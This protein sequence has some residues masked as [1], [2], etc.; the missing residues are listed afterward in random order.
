VTD[1]ASK[2]IAELSQT[3]NEHLY[4]YHVQDSPTISDAQYDALF[5]ELELL[6]AKHPELIKP[7]SPTHRVLFRQCVYV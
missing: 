5:K 6:E 3:L 2:K 7:D 4:R 1:K